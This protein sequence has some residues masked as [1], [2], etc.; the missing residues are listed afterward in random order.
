M[1][2]LGWAIFL[3]E[4]AHASATLVPPLSIHRQRM[5]ISASGGKVGLKECSIVS[6]I[7]SV[8]SSVQSTSNKNFLISFISRSNQQIDF[9]RSVLCFLFPLLEESHIRLLHLTI[10]CVKSTVS[11]AFSVIHFVVLFLEGKLLASFI[12]L[13]GTPALLY[14]APITKSIPVTKP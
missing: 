14:T 1:W 3:Q 13:I 9:A 5:T 8:C 11:T 2:Y 7:S 10:S 4:T 12:M 6:I